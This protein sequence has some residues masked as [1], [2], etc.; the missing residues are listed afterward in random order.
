M[1]SAIVPSQSNKYALNDP[2]G[3]FS[4]MSGSACFSLSDMDAKYVHFQP[5]SIGSSRH[6]FRRAQTHPAKLASVRRLV[7]NADDFGLTSGVN[8]GILESHQQGVVTS[9]TLMACGARFDEAAALAA[10]A[11]TL[12]VGCHVV[13]VDGSPLL[14]ETQVSSL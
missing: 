5:A 14:N 4:L 11:P 3:T 8:R 6:E 7:I 12:S 9:S 13:L 10:Q 1:E 2:R